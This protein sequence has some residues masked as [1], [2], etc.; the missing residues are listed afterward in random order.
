M[1][2]DVTGQ[3]KGLDF[4]LEGLDFAKKKFDPNSFTLS[5]ATFNQRAIKVYKRA[6]FK[7]LEE[8]MQDTNGDRY[9]FLRMKLIINN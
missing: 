4:L 3:G 9:E 2:P 1:K 8:Y 7:P 6:G 5:V